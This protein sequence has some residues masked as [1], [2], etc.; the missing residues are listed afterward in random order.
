[1]FLGYWNAQAAT[2][3]KF[4]G[5]WLL[6]GDMAVEE[7]AG[8]IRFVGRSDDVITSGG[9]RIGPA[10]IE[11]C[12]CRHAAVQAA[13]VVGLADEIRTESVVAFIVPR[14]GFEP[15]ESLGA[16]LQEHVARQLGHY[17]RPR[18]VRYVTE[19]PLTT[20]GKLM[21]HELRAL[22]MNLPKKI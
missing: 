16:E 21:R 4:R 20:T 7:A 6:T 8:L 13:A 5:D 22:A 15:S 9:Y 12:L 1:M 14:S 17:L 19:L 3:G 2:D 10:E 18:L 11:E